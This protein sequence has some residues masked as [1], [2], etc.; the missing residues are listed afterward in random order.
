MLVLHMNRTAVSEPGLYRLLQKE[1]MNYH[2]SYFREL[3]NTSY[4][5]SSSRDLAD[6]EKF[7]GMM[8][9]LPSRAPALRVLVILSATF[10]ERQPHGVR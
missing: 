6:M 8:V 1:K 3:S 9:S 7:A 2:S 5:D 4:C 10:H